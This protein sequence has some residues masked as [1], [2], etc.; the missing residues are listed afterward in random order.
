MPEY[1]D[2][3]AWKEI[4]GWGSLDVI[5]MNVS[6]S[7]SHKKTPSLCLFVCTRIYASILM[8][9]YMNTNIMNT[10]IFN[11]H[12]V[13]QQSSLKVTKGNLSFREFKKIL[14]NTF[15]YKSIMIKTYMNANIMKTQ[16]FYLIKYDI[17]VI[18]GRKKS[19]LCLF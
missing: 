7:T 13:W 11:F 1:E 14:H 2:L 12:Y 3:S 15:I 8:K 10:Q 9:I 16:I 4:F 19:L 5:I 6:S 17:K 18:E